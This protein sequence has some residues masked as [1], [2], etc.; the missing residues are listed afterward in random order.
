M[1]NLYLTTLIYLFITGGGVLKVLLNDIF[2]CY[3]LANFWG[4]Y[5]NDHLVYEVKP[6]WQKKIVY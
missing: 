4:K 6:Q 3:L 2:L 5:D 1:S